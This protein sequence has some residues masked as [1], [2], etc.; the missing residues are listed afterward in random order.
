M[1]E[2]LARH[3][4]PPGRAL[5]LGFSQGG[6]LALRYGL[7]RPEVFAGLA[8]LSGSLKKV[9]DLRAGLPPARKQ[10]IF[11]GHGTRDPLVPV[12]WSREVLAFL[13]GQGY[14]PVYRT[15]PI[16]HSIGPRLLQE[17]RAWVATT[18]PPASTTPT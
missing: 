1:R 10:A 18:L 5:L 4:T 3:R 7:P 8:V 11:I 17:L 12:G 15:F 2:V 13:E 9:E 14:R 16:G 6:A